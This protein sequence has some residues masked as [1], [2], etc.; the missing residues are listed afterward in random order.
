[1]DVI[2][3]KYLGNDNS[4]YSIAQPFRQGTMASLGGRVLAL[5]LGVWWIL[6]CVGLVVFRALGYRA[7]AIQ[8]K[9]KAKR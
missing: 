3:Q 6:G 2:S 4:L 5:A 1:V 9:L 8:N 7:A